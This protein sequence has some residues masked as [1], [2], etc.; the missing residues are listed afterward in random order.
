MTVAVCIVSYRSAMDV[1]LCIAALERLTYPDFE[2]I[3]C[4]NGGP[5][6][7]AEL[8]ARLPAKLA[9]G[10]P[11]TLVEAPGNIGYA[12]GCN[13]AMAQ[14][15]AARAWWI[16]NPDAEPDPGALA[17]LL[18]RLAVGDV[19]AVGG[20]LIFP[21]G[22]TQGHGG[23][24]SPYS[25]R[26]ISLGYGERDAANA[27]EVEAHQNYLLGASMLIGPPFL[28]SVG[29]MREDYFL[30]CEEVEW[31]MRGAQRG[32]KLGFA[33]G[34]RVMHRQGAITG[35]G[36]TIRIRPKLPIYLDDRNK[37]HLVRDTGG[38]PLLWLAIVLTFQ[39]F[40]RY[41]RKFAW[42]QML[43][44]LSGILAGLR[45]ERGVPTWLDQ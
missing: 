38:P 27:D 22:R 23:V 3:V 18:A 7:F 41:P 20:S 36:K 2:I 40:W 25:G 4:E 14:R 30:Y 44:A 5:F 16:V 35:S 10:Q 34:A 9:G 8:Q 1:C 37:L 43:Y 28:A 6:A 39:A 26:T 32:M 42:R 33:P 24:W 45:G 15:P 29:P 13:L 11:L 12:G 17:A 19:Q 21:D 31:F